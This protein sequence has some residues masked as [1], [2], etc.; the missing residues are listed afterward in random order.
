MTQKVMQSVCQASTWKFRGIETDR[1]LCFSTWRIVAL[2]IHPYHLSPAS[3]LTG[4]PLV[5]S[6]ICRRVCSLFNA[7]SFCQVLTCSLKGVL[8]SCMASG[9]GAG[10]STQN[11]KT[12]SLGL[13]RSFLQEARWWVHFS[14]VILLRRLTVVR[15]NWGGGKLAAFLGVQHAV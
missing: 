14:L 2:C 13:W 10:R 3:T 6:H 1:S 8:N 11:Q 7:L 4:L 5:L 9:S 12:W 15:H